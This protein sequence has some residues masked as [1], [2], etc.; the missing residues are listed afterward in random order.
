MTPLSFVNEPFVIILTTSR[1]VS[2]KTQN[3]KCGGGVTSTFLINSLPTYYALS[4][5]KLSPFGLD[6]KDYRLAFSYVQ[7]QPGH[8]KERYGNYDLTP[9]MSH[10]T[11]TRKI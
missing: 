4:C 9:I 6:Y 5:N 3:D 1:V 11:E 8:Q 7:Y 10:Q 2:G